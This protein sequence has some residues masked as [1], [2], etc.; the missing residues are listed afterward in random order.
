MTLDEVKTKW[1]EKIDRLRDERNW[2]NEHNFKIEAMVKSQVIEAVWNV[3]YDLDRIKNGGA[4]E[5]KEC[6]R[7]G[8][9]VEQTSTPYTQ[10][11]AAGR[12]SSANKPEPYPPH[13]IGTDEAN[14]WLRGYRDGALDKEV[15]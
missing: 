14:D 5:D 1:R 3:L 12:A 6:P 2:L 7:Q 11:Y 4:L 8:E 15:S 13:D 10:G 9:V